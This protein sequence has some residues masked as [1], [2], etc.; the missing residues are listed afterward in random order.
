[1]VIVRHFRQNSGG[2][3]QRDRGVIIGQHLRGQRLECSQ[4]ILFGIVQ[5]ILCIAEDEDGALTGAKQDYGPKSTGFPAAL[6]SDTQLDDAAAKVRVDESTLRVPN[7]FAEGGVV[8]PRLAGESDEDLG[9]EDAKAAPTDA[10]PQFSI[11]LSASFSNQFISLRRRL[12]PFR[13]ATSCLAQ[14]RGKLALT[15]QKD[16]RQIG[17]IEFQIE[18]QLNRRKILSD[19][20]FPANSAYAVPAQLKFE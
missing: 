19:N 12:T 20:N 13:R 7:R 8:E 3:R 17:V 2:K 9:L 5:F 6:A 11:T 4:F 1:M 16:L 14:R 18:F 10:I 15:R